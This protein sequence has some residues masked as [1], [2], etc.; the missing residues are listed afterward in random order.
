MTLCVLGMNGRR[1]IGRIEIK[2]HNVI[3]AFRRL[4]NTSVRTMG[5]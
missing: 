2:I 4:L 3:G 5:G 1:H